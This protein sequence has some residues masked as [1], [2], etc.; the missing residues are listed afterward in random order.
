[1]VE[2]NTMIG[3]DVIVLCT[4]VVVIVLVE[5]GKMLLELVAVTSD[6]G[7]YE[8]VLRAVVGRPVS[9]AFGHIVKTLVTMLQTD[10]PAVRLILSGSTVFGSLG[11]HVLVVYTVSWKRISIY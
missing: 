7:M 8:D 10:R 5:I 3:E 1:M 6:P 2:L 4:L 9:E 11:V